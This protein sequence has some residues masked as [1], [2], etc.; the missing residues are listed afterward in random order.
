MNG[1]SFLGLSLLLAAVG[2]G[3]FKLGPWIEKMDDKLTH[4]LEEI[5]RRKHS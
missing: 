3:F 2:I 5:T 4:D 1:Y